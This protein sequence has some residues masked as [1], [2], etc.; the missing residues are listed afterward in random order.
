MDPV[1]GTVENVIDNLKF[2]YD[3]ASQNRLLKVNDL[4]NSPQ[5]FKDNYTSTANDFS[6]DNNG[7][8]TADNNKGIG[9]IIYNHLNLPIKINFGVKGEINYLYNAT[10]QKL[11]K[12]VKEVMYQI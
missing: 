7:N 9:S 11:Q 12:F 1:A 2:V 10:L 5:G 4:S 8:M 3:T 6:Y